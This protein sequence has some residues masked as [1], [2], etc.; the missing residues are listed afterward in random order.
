MMSSIHKIYITNFQ[1]VIYN[2]SAK[3]GVLIVV[4]QLRVISEVIF[5]RIRIR[6][7]NRTITSGF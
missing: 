2:R 3:K 6:A 1:Y 4:E 7:Q 5:C